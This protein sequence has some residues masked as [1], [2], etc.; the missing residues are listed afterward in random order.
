MADVT[1]TELR[2]HLYRVLDEVLATGQ[3]CR[4]RRGGRIVLLVP[5]VAPHPPWDFEA[6]PFRPLVVGDVDALVDG[7]SVA[8]W[9]SDGGFE[10]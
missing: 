5:E 1:P 2:S 9:H 3:P 7:P 4:V 10:L 8:E 6:R